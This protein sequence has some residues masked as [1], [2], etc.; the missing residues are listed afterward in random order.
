MNPKTF[1]KITA[2]LM[3]IFCAQIRA[4]TTINNVN[5]F[6]YGANIG[7]INGYADNTNGAV[8]GEYVCSGCIYSANVGWINLGNGAPANGVQYQNNS[9]ADFGVNHDGLGNL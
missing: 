7:W 6:A 8:I 3:A 4:A 2:F 9:A 1:I 5:S